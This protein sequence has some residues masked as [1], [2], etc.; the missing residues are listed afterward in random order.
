MNDDTPAT[1]N[2]WGQERRL[3][4]IDSR[5]QYARQVNRGDLI[6][7]FGIS[8]PKASQD[9]ADYIER[10]P[11]NMEYDG[12]L[13]RYVPTATFAPRFIADTAEAYLNEL[14]AVQMKIIPADTSFFGKMPAAGLVDTPARPLDAAKVAAFVDA[15]N[16][17]KTLSI[18]YH[19]MR[20]PE[21]T[22]RIISPHALGF[23]G[24][25][26]HVRAFCH[27][28]ERYRDFAIGRSREIHSSDAPTV[29]AEGDVLWNERVPVI[30]EPNPKL[31][32]WQRKTVEE[33]YGIE[34]GGEM[35]LSC[36]RAM[37]FY[38]VRHLNLLTDE[39]ETHPERHHVVLRNRETVEK[40]IAEDELA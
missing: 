40:W 21:P 10:A 4:F 36:R 13:K 33:D 18:T 19:S 3:E 30:L 14:Y 20:S 37:L 23:D 34:P 38:T 29:S 15:I 32:D 17:K 31:A 28:R 1:R 27:R 6:D 12:S 25:R 16:R 9:L 2:R 22:E 5:L 24:L 39:A 26:W 8:P 7:F 11:G 35:E